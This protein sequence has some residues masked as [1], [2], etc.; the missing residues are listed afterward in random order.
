[1][2]FL[3]QPFDPSSVEPARDYVPLPSGDYVAQIID[4]DFKP[5]K[6]GN[7]NYLELTFKVL[8]G[9][10]KGQLVW[11][12]LNLDNPNAQ[13]VEIAQRELA[14]ICAAAGITQAITDSVALHN[15]PMVIRVEFVP[16]G[17]RMQRDGNDVKGYKPLAAAAAPQQ[18]Q[19]APQPPQAPPQPA[20]PQ[21]AAQTA[22]A[23][24]PPW[25]RAG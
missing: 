14:A 10:A 18:A 2:A 13:A 9:P 19:A 16:A 21:P 17:G 1:M 20:A 7:A 8:D 15:R 11:A 3:G 12:R 4:S 5:T 6:A 25:A 23:G 22:P 24:A